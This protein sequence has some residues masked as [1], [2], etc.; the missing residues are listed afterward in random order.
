M[1]HAVFFT[2]KSGEPVP[3]E[4]EVQLYLSQQQ[5]VGGQ[6]S[7]EQDGKGQ[8]SAE[9]L[10]KD[11]PRQSSRKTEESSRRRVADKPKKPGGMK[12]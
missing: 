9:Q 7:R 1:F 6:S 3:S 4:M 5:S 10:H 11:T 8:T 2:S 12:L